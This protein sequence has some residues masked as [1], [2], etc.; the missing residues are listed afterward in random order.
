MRLALLQ[1]QTN[2]TLKPPNISADFGGNATR[3]LPKDGTTEKLLE[4]QQS[5]HR[6]V[7]LDC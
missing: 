7:K 6:K 5:G 4:I 1:P 3:S 2:V